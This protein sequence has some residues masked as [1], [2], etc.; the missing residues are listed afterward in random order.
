MKDKLMLGAPESKDHDSSR[1]YTISSKD[2]SKRN[3][4]NKNAEREYRK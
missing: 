1:K 4:N 3:D 2:W